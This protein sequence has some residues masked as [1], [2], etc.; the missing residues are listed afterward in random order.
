MGVDVPPAQRIKYCFPA[1]Q[2]NLTFGGTS[3]QQNRDFSK[4]PV[5]QTLFSGYDV[6][7]PD[8]GWA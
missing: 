5:I 4:F 2:G 8:E 6:V 1:L 7:L 3:T